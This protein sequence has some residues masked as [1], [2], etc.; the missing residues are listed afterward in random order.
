MTYAQTLLEALAQS[1]RSGRD[2]SIDAVGHESA[3][4]SLKRGLDLRVSTLQAL[5][6]V[7][8][9]EFYVGPLRET[10]SQPARS[11]SSRYPEL[12]EQGERL[13]SS[14]GVVREAGLSRAD[15]Q[16]LRSIGEVLGRLDDPDLRTALASLMRFAHKHVA[17]GQ[18]A[19]GDAD[20]AQ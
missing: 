3:I 8:G 15:H 20:T 12:Q 16:L 5:C 18:G 9:L 6:R 7:L 14:A 19:G 11:E 4:R 10:G 13:V 17:S 1:G 2:V